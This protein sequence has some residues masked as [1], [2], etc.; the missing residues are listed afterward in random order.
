MCPYFY[1]RVNSEATNSKVFFLF[2]PICNSITNMVDVR[3]CFKLYA[4]PWK[5]LKKKKNRRHDV[6]DHASRVK[7]NL[8]NARVAH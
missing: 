3:F 6:A 8:T 7:T 4:V 2:P 1:L 5:Q